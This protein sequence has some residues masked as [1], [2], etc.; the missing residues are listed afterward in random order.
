MTWQCASCEATS[1]GSAVKRSLSDLSIC[2]WCESEL[3]RRNC[4]RCRNC[5]AVLPLPFGTAHHGRWCVPCDK[6][7]LA[8]RYQRTRDAKLAYQ[9]AYNERNAATI[10]ARVA[11]H[12]EANRDAINA[13]RRAAR[14]ASPERSRAHFRRWMQNN[15][16]RNRERARRWREAR[17]GVSA[18]YN[19]LYRVRKKLAILRGM[20]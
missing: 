14:A 12:T 5:N 1:A 11:A 9:R 4:R 18:A 15:P 8:A 3:A 2:D 13:R 7:Y 6:A 20:R 10:R 17:P 19:R 16:D